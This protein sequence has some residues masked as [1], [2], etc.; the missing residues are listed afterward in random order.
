MEIMIME[1]SQSDYMQMVNTYKKNGWL[2]LRFYSINH[3]HKIIYCMIPKNATTLFKTMMITNSDHRVSY[4]QS[5]QGVH[6]YLRTNKA[7]HL[8]DPYCLNNSEYFKFVILRN[9][10]NRLVSA[11]LDKFV[12][13][14]T[15]ALKPQV[16]VIN[17]VYGFLGLKPDIYKSIT[18]SQFV[19]YL[20]RTEDLQLDSHWRPQSSFLSSG[21]FEFDFI[22]QFEKLDLV[23]EYLEEKFAF[24]INKA[25]LTPA[26]QI[27]ITT[28]GNF[29]SEEKLH[30]KYPEDLLSLES[31]PTVLHLYTPELENLVRARYSKDIEIYERLFN[32]SLKIS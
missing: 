25:V 12:K 26:H 1:S 17:N 30:D 18:F 5:S 15:L 31:F 9:P 10:F 11:Y 28:Y 27:H 22:G 4:E 8:T 7:F 19:Q 3:K 2:R 13:H 32:E 6:S 29:H 14:K 24:K 21:L 23:I 16:N 20:V